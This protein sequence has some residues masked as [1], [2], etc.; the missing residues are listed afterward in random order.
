M[1]VAVGLGHEAQFAAG[2]LRQGGVF[3]DDGIAD[4]LDDGRGVAAGV[5][6]QVDDGGQGLGLR[7]Q[8]IGQQREPIPP[9]R[10]RTGLWRQTHAAQYSRSALKAKLSS[11][12][13][14]RQACSKRRR[15]VVIL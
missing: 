9:A 5:V 14:A 7:S 13:P 12:A 1:P 8:E 3:I 10:T 6:N 11:H 2:V 4:E 15:S